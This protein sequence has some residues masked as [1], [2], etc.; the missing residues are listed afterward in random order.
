M[1]RAIALHFPCLVSSRSIWLEINNSRGNDSRFFI[2]ALS[3]AHVLQAERDGKRGVSIRDHKRAA[4]LCNRNRLPVIV[5]QNVN[6]RK[7]GETREGHAESTV[8]LSVIA[9]LPR[10]YVRNA[11]SSCTRSWV[12]DPAWF[13][14]YRCF[15]I[16]MITIADTVPVSCCYVTI[17]SYR[18]RIRR[19]S[20]AFC[21]W[22]GIVAVFADW[23]AVHIQEID[24]VHWGHFSYTLRDDYNCIDIIVNCV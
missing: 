23:H 12:H 24:N 10:M 8:P 18:R 11:N 5:R 7:E 15:G 17:G 9:E 20:P 3:S 4:L 21:Q 2:A 19:R 22:K 16:A 6:H 14:S 1:F 13:W